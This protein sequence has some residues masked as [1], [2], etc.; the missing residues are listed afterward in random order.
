MPAFV[1]AVTA[2]CPSDAPIVCVEINC[3]GIGSAPR[4]RWS[5]EL[6]ASL[7]P[8]LPGNGRR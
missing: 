8:V 5:T 6:C 3:I 1:E 2:L 4:L 7:I